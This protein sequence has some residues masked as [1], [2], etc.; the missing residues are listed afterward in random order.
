MDV[1]D[2]PM[3]VDKLNNTRNNYIVI[4]SKEIIDNLN[5]KYNMNLAGEEI[6]LEEN[7]FKHTYALNYLFLKAKE[8]P[9]F[10][11]RLQNRINNYNEK[12]QSYQNKIDNA[13]D[14][15]EKFS[16]ELDKGLFISPELL[17][18]SEQFLLNQAEQSLAFAKTKMDTTT[19]R[20]PTKLSELDPDIL[21]M[22]QSKMTGKGK[23][24]SKKKRKSKRKKKS[25]SKKKTRRK[26][27]SKI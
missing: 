26:S 19:V 10:I 8:N 15:E 14:N 23:R 27:K 16:L 18:A 3:D 22:V 25:K 2:W 20:K 6:N 7:W 4:K 9:K 1:N 5:E 24:K 21:S 12:I 13:E 11:N 17:E